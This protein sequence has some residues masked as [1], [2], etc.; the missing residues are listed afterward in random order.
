MANKAAIL[1]YQSGF[2]KSTQSLAK[3]DEHSG[4]VVGVSNDTG[5]FNAFIALLN[6][7]HIRYEVL[8]ENHEVNKVRYSAGQAIYIPTNQP[9]YRLVKSIFSTQ[10]SFENNTF[11]DVSTWNLALAFNLDYAPLDKGDARGLELGARDTLK[12]ATLNSIQSDAYA[13]AF[14]LAALLCPRPCFKP[15]LKPALKCVAAKSPFLPFS[16][17]AKI[18][19]CSQAV[20]LFLKA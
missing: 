20:S 12:Q 3:K 17:M 16:T 15:Y 9:Q 2:V 10:T 14:F 4:F 18:S 1:D 5:R 8:T 19:R 6:Q 13:Y 7:H 11:Y